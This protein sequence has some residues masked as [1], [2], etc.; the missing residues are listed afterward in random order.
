MAYHLFNEI[1]GDTNI[2]KLI[3]G[4]MSDEEYRELQEAPVYRPNMGD[5]I[6]DSG[7]LRKV[8]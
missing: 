5:V 4:L 7:G 3:N 8:R 6:R 1:Y 2:C